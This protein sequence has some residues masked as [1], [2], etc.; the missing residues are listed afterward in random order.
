MSERIDRQMI[1]ATY[2]RKS[3]EELIVM[4]TTNAAG[5]SPEALEVVQQEINRRKLSPGLQQAVE[6]QQKTLTNEEVDQ[7]CYLLQSL[8]CPHTGSTDTPL[9]A[10]KVISVRSFLLFTETRT[11]IVI[12]HPEVVR[13]ACVQATV[14]TALLGWWSPRG[15]ISSIGA[16][17]SN[18]VN[19]KKAGASAPTS[20]LKTFVREHCGAIE[21][22]KNDVEALRNLLIRQ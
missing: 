14:Q 9:N 20:Y 15:L 16:I 1:E 21:A 4:L 18:L 11:G 5:L 12:G 19:R 7:Y 17:T 10:T 13:R 22:N 3:D 8:P 6:V 2:R